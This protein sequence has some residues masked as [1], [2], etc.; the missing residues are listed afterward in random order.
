MDFILQKSK[1]KWS[2]WEHVRRYAP[3]GWRDLTG[4]EKCSSE[5]S[6]IAIITSEYEV[7][8][9]LRHPAKIENSPPGLDESHLNN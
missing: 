6:V 2:E 5:M 8:K 4:L 3:D 1:D 9:I 7:K